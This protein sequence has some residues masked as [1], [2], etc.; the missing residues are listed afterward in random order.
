MIQFHSPSS[1]GPHLDSDLGP[2][3]NPAPLHNKFPQVFPCKNSDLCHNLVGS[4]AA[5]ID[6]LI[7]R[8]FDVQCLEPWQEITQNGKSG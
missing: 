7:D 6:L 1:P 4:R 5:Y 3:P 2:R 8:A